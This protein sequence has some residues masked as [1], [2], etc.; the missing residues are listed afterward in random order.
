M[1]KKP[2]LS[3]VLL[4]RKEIEVRAK[5]SP[6]ILVRMT[7]AERET[8]KEVAQSLNLTATEYLVKCH[9]LVSSKLSGK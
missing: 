5:K 4:T 8:I 2:D 7:E 1:K 9:E 6:A 3:D